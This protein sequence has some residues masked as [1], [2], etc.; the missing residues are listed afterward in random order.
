MHNAMRITQKLPLIALGCTLSTLLWA[1]DGKLLG[2][3]GVTSI[4]GSAGGGLIPWATLGTYATRE[5]YGVSVA[6]SKTNVDDYRLS[7]Y[8]L[9][10]AARDRVELSVARMDFEIDPSNTRIRQTVA[11]VKVRACGDLVYGELPLVSIGLQHKMLNDKEVAR[12]VG[13]DKTKGMDVYVSTAKAWIDGIAHR[14]TFAN[15]NLRYSEANELG[16]L[17]YGGPGSGKKLHLEA[18]AGVFLTQSL[19]VGTEYRQKDNH[20]TVFEE[21]DW[22]DVFVAWFPTKHLA[23]TAAWARLGEIATLDSQNGVHVALQAQF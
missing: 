14:I 10:F 3:A 9:T 8:G 19:A 6:T 18:A 23:V 13:A 21:D 1:G 22:M 16:L 20:L 17:G 11:G 4:E 2:T 12:S 7:T 15:L 5:E